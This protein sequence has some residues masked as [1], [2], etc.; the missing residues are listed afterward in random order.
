[1]LSS[2]DRLSI[3]NLYARYCAYLDTGNIEAWSQCFTE[4][5]VFDTYQSWAGRK[6]ILEY[7]KKVLAGRADKPW[8]N[9]QHW[10]SNLIVEG[11]GAQARAIC[12]LL[13]AGKL[14]TNGEFAIN[15]QGTYE[16]DL[17]KIDGRWLFKHRKVHFDTPSPD[18]IPK[19]T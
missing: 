14:R 1:M 16:D 4:D 13:V 9:G 8:M 2:E 3:Q 5:G 19:A 18:I 15:I 10:N 6:T 7:G 11:D 12:Y 17:A